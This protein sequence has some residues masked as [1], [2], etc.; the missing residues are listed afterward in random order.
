[1]TL[2]QAIETAKQK[3]AGNEAAFKWRGL[4]EAARPED[5]PKIA[6]APPKRAAKAAA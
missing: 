1:M 6:E 4:P 2:T 5:L 3:A